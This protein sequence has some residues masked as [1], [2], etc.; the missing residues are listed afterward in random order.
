MAQLALF[1][2]CWLLARGCAGPLH[3]SNFALNNADGHYIMTA[4]I[5]IT[6]GRAVPVEQ[7]PEKHQVHIQW[8]PVESVNNYDSS[9]LDE[10]YFYRFR[11]YDVN[12]NETLSLKAAPSSVEYDEK[13]FQERQ[14][15][16]INDSTGML[17]VLERDTGRGVTT[18]LMMSNVIKSSTYREDLDTIRYIYRPKFH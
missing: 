8:I 16:T 15:L 2:T 11:F 4:L 7:A 14:W 18:R 6:K 13:Y 12:E 3:D 10:A 17:V 1:L 9:F 5:D